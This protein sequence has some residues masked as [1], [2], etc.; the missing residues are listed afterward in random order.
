MGRAG[1]Q[2]SP[3]LLQ[4]WH[5]GNSAA[6]VCAIHRSHNRQHSDIA[7]T[8][9]P[10]TLHAQQMMAQAGADVERVPAVLTLV[11]RALDHAGLADTFRLLPDPDVES[12]TRGAKSYPE[13]S[14]QHHAV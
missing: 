7:R 8:L 6:R 13:T 11:Q 12:A 10:F 5:S 4:S 2:L 3:G 9:R 14:A 1:Y